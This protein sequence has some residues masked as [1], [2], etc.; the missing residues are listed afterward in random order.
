MSVLQFNQQQI[1]ATFDNMTTTGGGYILKGRNI[2]LKLPFA[3]QA[4]Y[5]HGWQSWSLAAWSK[6]ATLPTPKPAILNPMQIDP[7]YAKH[8]CPNG[9]WL[10]AVELP[11]GGILLLGAL[12]LDSHVQMREGALQGW[13]EYENA[14]PAGFEWF[15]GFGAEEKVFASYAELL[16]QRLGRGRAKT[17]YRVWCSWYSLYT[18]IDEASLNNIFDGLGDLPFDVLQVDDGWQI[19]IGDW[20]ANGKFPS[21]MKTLADKIKATG[22]KAGLWLAPLLA[23]P[24]SSIYQDHR[25]WLLHDEQGKLVSAGFNWGEQLYALDTTHPAVLEWLAALMKQVRAWGYEYIKLD[26]LY[27]GALPGK[28]H[29]AMPRE[30]AYRQGLAAIREALG[31]EAYFL[32]CGAPILP[33]LGLCDAMRIGPDVAAEWESY[34]DAVLLYNPATPGVKNAIRTTLSRLWLAPLVHTDPDVVFFRSTETRLTPEQNSLLQDLALVCGFKATS[35]PQQWLTQAQ[36]ADLRAFLTHQPRIKR[37]GKY[38]YQLDERLV[39]FTPAMN[40]PEAPS[41]LSALA[42]SIT[43]WLGS[44]P[45][46]L[47]VLDRLGKN[48]VEKLKNRL[49]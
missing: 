36:S 29:T 17:A 15:V 26:F 46:V 8:P 5:H 43:G 39:D 3:A 25:D 42:G 13:Y 33:S 6:P 47:K 44:Q 7:L 19:G 11:R 1:T 4:Y 28:R 18:A 22:R 37:T 20:Q 30:A 40:L 24:S 32:T 10:G 49:G 45:A 21:G 23:V 38:T 9:S 35:D 12:N 34:R 2:A 16:G 48:A 27:A 14:D 31:E 41:G